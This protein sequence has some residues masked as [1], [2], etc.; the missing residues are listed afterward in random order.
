MYTTFR[1]H[2]IVP[3]YMRFEMT[4]NM[5]CIAQIPLLR[6]CKDIFCCVLTTFKWHL[7]NSTWRSV[8]DNLYGMRLVWWIDLFNTVSK[9]SKHCSTFLWL[10]LHNKSARIRGSGIWSYV[11]RRY[12]VCVGSRKGPPRFLTEGRMS[13]TKSAFACVYCV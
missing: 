2:C 4:S 13:M 10:A 9:I 8:L 3:T 6:L 12:C 7:F 5:V 11:F 1:C